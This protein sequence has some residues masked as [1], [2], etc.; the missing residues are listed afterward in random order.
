MAPLWMD[1][2]RNLSGVAGPLWY[3]A[4]RPEKSYPQ[5]S[6]PPQPWITCI[7][8]TEAWALLQAALR[9]LPGTSRFKGDCNACIDMIHA[10]LAVATSAKRVLARVYVMLL[11]AP[12]DV[13]LERLLWMLV[14]KSAAHVGKLR[15]SNG[16]LL[17][18]EDVERQRWSGQRSQIR[19]GGA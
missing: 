2:L 15:L 19:S 5:P 3:F 1:Q 18:K 11:T 13:G 10:G 14:H 17:T 8:G 4:K 7:G 12:E 6:P 16:D 9:K